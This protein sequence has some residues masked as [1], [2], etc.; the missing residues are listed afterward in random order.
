MNLNNVSLS[1]LGI[2][3]LLTVTIFA[4]TLIITGNVESHTIIKAEITVGDEVGI[5][6]DNSSLQ[7]GEV[8]PGGKAERALEYEGSN[9][10]YITREADW[11]YIKEKNLSESQEIVFE[12]RPSWSSG[13]RSTTVHVYEFGRKPGFLEKTFLIEGMRIPHTNETDSKARINISE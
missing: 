12:A 7:F 10:L 11:I 5:N 13:K 4:V 2:L 1:L 8:L 9:Y 3:T 6:L